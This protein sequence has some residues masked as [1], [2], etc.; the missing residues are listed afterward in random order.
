MVFSSD[1]P[2]KIVRYV[3]FPAFAFIDGCFRSDQGAC[4]LLSVEAMV[5]PGE[6]NPFMDPRVQG[7]WHPCWE[8]LL[9]ISI[10]AVLGY[11][12]AK[13]DWAK[14]ELDVVKSE[15]F[16]YGLYAAT[17]CSPL[18]DGVDATRVGDA[19][20]L[21]EWCGTLKSVM[22]AELNLL[23]CTDCYPPRCFCCFGDLTKTISKQTLK[24]PS[25]APLAPMTQMREMA[26]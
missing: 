1:Q 20:G 15:Y 18:V 8:G 3:L 5:L 22:L 16:R 9:I 12:Q 6:P 11:L 14:A 4:P 17:Q 25:V 23:S 21:Q 19:Q 26:K 2:F 7:M 10:S 24:N 13:Y